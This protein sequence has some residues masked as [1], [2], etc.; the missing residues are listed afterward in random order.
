M[1]V[2]NQD[3]GCTMKKN[4]PVAEVMTPHPRSVQISQKLSDV[5]AALAD[6]RMHHLPVV[7]GQRLV[8]IITMTD[9]LEF[10]FEP[11]TPQ[12]NRDEYLDQHFQ[13]GQIMQTEL[14]T[15]PSD[16]TVRDAAK[17]LTTGTLHAVPVVD[18]NQNLIGIVTSTDIVSY[19]LSQIS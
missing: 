5:R 11:R 6:G 7:D 1:G 10:G 9:L 16:S 4:T 8:G 2:K 12:E 17:A 13:I 18:E 3:G 15:I 19:L 14:V